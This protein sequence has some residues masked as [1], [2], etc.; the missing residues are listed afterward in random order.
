MSESYRGLKY[1]TVNAWVEEG[2]GYLQF[3]RP[4]AMN[5]V[6]PKILEEATDVLNA[7]SY[8]PEV[9]VIII[10]GNEKVF[11]AGADLAEVAKMT[12]FEARNY[13][14]G[15]HRV[16]AALEDNHKPSIA[17]V[18]G[19]ALG[20]GFEFTLSSDIRIASDDATFGMPE[21]N[22][23]IMP[24]GGGTQRWLRS[25]SIC[26]AK[27]YIFTGDFFNAQQALQ[28]DLINMVV[29][30]AEVMATAKKIAKKISKKSAL[31]LREAKM[32]INNSMNLDIKSGLK[33][34]QIAWSMLFASEDQKEGMGA[35]LESRP[36]VFKGK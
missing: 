15:V 30:N 6:N 7:Y 13:L 9:R 20:G 28:M 14:D 16:Q 2:I 27:Y 5:A 19:L 18:Q 36:A 26:T 29:P 34:E 35:F 4:K 8:D 1:E 11:C 12:A 31:A 24:G 32:C 3:N 22:L 17:A 10:C 25:G 23:G 21:I 33:A